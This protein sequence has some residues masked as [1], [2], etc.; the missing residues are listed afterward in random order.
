MSNLEGLNEN[1]K[2]NRQK[3]YLKWE[4]GNKDVNGAF[5]A[6]QSQIDKGFNTKERRANTIGSITEKSGLQSE[7]SL[8]QS[9]AHEHVCCNKLDDL[10]K[11]YQLIINEQ[12]NKLS[13]LNYLIQ[14][15]SKLL[16][17]SYNQGLEDAKNAKHKEQ[18]IL[19]NNRLLRERDR[20]IQ[21]WEERYQKEKKIG[22]ER[23]EEIKELENRIKELSINVTVTT[24]TEG[25]EEEKNQWKNKFIQLN[26]QFN[27]TEQQV[28]VL[29]NEIDMLKQQQKKS[30]VK[31]TTRRRTIAKEISQP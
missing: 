13:E 20:Q 10:S 22:E 3:G 4:L 11:Q 14:Q 19:E 23:E 30:E 8:D 17:E 24:N 6:Q 2:Y 21:E 25:L 27:E 31:T 26:K 28:V 29:E 18:Q 7:R 15:H 12:M 1:Y 16:I 9:N 5:D